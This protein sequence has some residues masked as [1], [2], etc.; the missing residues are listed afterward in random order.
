MIGLNGPPVCPSCTRQ[1]TAESGSDAPTGSR[2]DSR[3]GVPFHELPPERKVNLH[4]GRL[5]V[6]EITEEFKAI[7]KVL[8]DLMPFV[9]EDYYPNCATPAYREAV[10]AA[11]MYLPNAATHEPG[12]NEKPLK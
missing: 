3:P 5:G 11:K 7:A 2:V 8:T 4:D 1:R 6:Q 12:A 9:L 10:E